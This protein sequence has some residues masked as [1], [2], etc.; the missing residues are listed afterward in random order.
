MEMV[1]THRWTRKEYARMGEAGVFHPEVETEL[2]AGEMVERSP[3]GSYH[4]TAIRKV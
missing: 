3:Q 4:F 1:R 2:I